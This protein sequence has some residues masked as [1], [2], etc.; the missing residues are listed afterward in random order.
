MGEVTKV[1]VFLHAVARRR[2]KGRT[3]IYLKSEYLPDTLYPLLI[4]GLIRA[5]RRGKRRG[6]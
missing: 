6:S 5:C 2:W 3:I 4:P 1:R